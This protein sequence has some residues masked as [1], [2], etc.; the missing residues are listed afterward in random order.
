MPSGN[1]GVGVPVGHVVFV[2]W[3]ISVGPAVSDGHDV[4]AGFGI[5]EETS[6]VTAVLVNSAV[7]MSSSMTINLP[8]AAL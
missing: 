4:L 2:G 3:G 5:S 6:T 1:N 7:T 8:T